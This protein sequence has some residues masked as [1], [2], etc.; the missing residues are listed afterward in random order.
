MDDR[1]LGAAAMSYEKMRLGTDEHYMSINT[2]GEVTMVG[3]DWAT[4][5][6]DQAIRAYREME[7]KAVQGAVV[8]YLRERG[9]TVE[10]PGGQ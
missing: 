4:T 6:A 5:I 8:Q 1:L 10:P 7:D 9:W 3:M 2:N